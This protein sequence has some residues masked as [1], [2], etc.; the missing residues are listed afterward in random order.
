[1]VNCEKS[2][3]RVE[4][5]CK[6]RILKQAP[7]LLL[8]AILLLAGLSGCGAKDEE[9][10]TCLADMY[11]RELVIGYPDDLAL[12]ESVQA[13]CPGVTLEPQSDLLAIESVAAGKLDAFVAGRYLLE[14][15]LEENPNAGLTILDEPLLE[16]YSGLAL[17]DTT[18]VEN[19]VARVNECIAELLETGVLADMESRWL[20]EGDETMP[21][22]ELPENPEYTL[23]VAT[24][25][26]Q[27]PY[28][29]MKD[30]EL[31]GFDVELAT[32][33]AAYLGCGIRFETA[34]FTSML[35]G[36]AE[37]KYDM[38][39]SN[40]YITEERAAVVTF[41]DAYQVFQI[42]F[43]VR[44][45]AG[46]DTASSEGFWAN[47]SRGFQNTFV[48]ES[49]WKTVLSGLGVTLLI[50]VGGFAVANAMGVVFCA[51]S[52][53]KRKIGRTISNIY[54]GLMQGTPVVVLLL[55]LYY[56]IF[57]KSRING[58]WVAILG[59]GISS[60]ASLAQQFR[61]GVT[62]V[63]K[64][65]K[66][67]ALA[68]GFT[69]AQV[70]FGITLPQAVR[71]VLPGYFSAL[72]ALLKGTSVV[73]YIAVVD[74]TKAS[75]IIRSSTY[76]AFFPLLSV[77]VVY[78]LISCGLLALMKRIQKKLAPKR[79]TGAEVTK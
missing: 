5:M 15:Y 33:V 38:V 68:L 27:K 55:I 42:S 30:N 56:V 14:G 25:G 61:G 10:I 78:L 34:S 57:G 8:A 7:C 22:I 26:Q 75:D 49:R 45:S 74:L 28:T 62:A 24:Y 11:D 65:Q 6:K 32:R 46:E 12:Q 73:G 1:M 16:Y 35:M 37:G 47:V 3:T 69:R 19:Y 54:S 44:A 4:H 50:T 79:R 67:A 72:I 76:E 29:Y 31:S 63:R 66:E 43:V 40:L 53:S 64:G 71:T 36:V 59:F 70:F 60:G 77:A 51:L 2:V 23:C 48:K 17:S 18:P 58:I 39:A 13:I 41:S 52:M 9:Y 20:T 21:E